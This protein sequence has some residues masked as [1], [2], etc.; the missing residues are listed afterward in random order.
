MGI[1]HRLRIVS[2]LVALC[3]I[4]G[5]SPGSAQKFPG[6]AP[7][8]PLGWNSW[9]HVG[10]NVSETTLEAAA[11]AMVSSGMKAAGYQYVVVDDCWQGSRD[12]DGFIRADP[13]RFP[14]GMKAVAD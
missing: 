14:H 10:C 4:L 6:L 8:P 13:Q 9:N 5:S 1:Q 7:T 12:A 2:R 3:V 11:D